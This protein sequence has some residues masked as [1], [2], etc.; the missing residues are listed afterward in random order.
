MSPSRHPACTGQHVW[1][2]PRRY[3]R[4][5][6]ERR[7][8]AETI[9]R[10]NP[11]P[12]ESISKRCRVIGSTRTLTHDTDTHTPA[13]ARLAHTRH[14]SRFSTKRDTPAIGHRDT[15][16]P[17]RAHTD[18]RVTSHVGGARGTEGQGLRDR[19]SARATAH[20]APPL[21]ERKAIDL[22]RIFAKVV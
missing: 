20:T 13:G 12:N 16:R 10:A 19:E 21:K 8:I 15:R 3:S 9:G 22:T 18:I 1:P 2:A 7:C 14:V 6:R 4:N 17:T 5:V 11:I